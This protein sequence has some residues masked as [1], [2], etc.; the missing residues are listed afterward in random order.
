M[1]GGGLHGPAQDSRPT[2]VQV[3]DPDVNEIERRALSEG[4]DSAGGCLTPEILSGRLI[5]RVRNAGRVFQAGATVVPLD[6]DTV[7]IARLVSG[8]TPSWKT[9]G[10]AVTV[11]DMVFDR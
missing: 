4:T 11:S 1:V 9:E 3:D 6:S 7:N 2:V 10:S 8:V 5:D